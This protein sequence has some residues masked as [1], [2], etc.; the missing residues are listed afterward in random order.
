ME[1]KNVDYNLGNFFDGT[2]FTAP[3]NGLYSFYACCEQGASSYGYISLYLNGNSR[4][5]ART[6]TSNDDYG[7]RFIN[8]YTTMKLVKNDKVYVGFY[9]NLY[10]TD[11]APAT[12]FE[13]RLIARL[14][15]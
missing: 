13:G 10:A 14:D 1:W 7:G 2:Y 3:E 8:I 9:G 11:H 12:F 6:R 5:Y 15:E 4:I